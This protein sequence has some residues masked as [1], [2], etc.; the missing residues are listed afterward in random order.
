MGIFD[1]KSSQSGAEGTVGA[2]TEAGSPTSINL[3]AG[4]DLA[5]ATV[6]V[7]NEF[8]DPGALDLAARIS[9]GSIDVLSEFAGTVERISGD[10]FTTAN[11]L[12][13]ASLDV[14]RDFGRDALELGEEALNTG[15]RA[16][17]ANTTVSL[18]A[19]NLS[20]DVSAGAF[21]LAADL[22]DN[23]AIFA[24]D[25][26][27][28]QGALVRDLFERTVTAVQDTGARFLNSA[29]EL[30]ARESTNTEGRLEAVTNR[31]ILVGGGVLAIA[32]AVAGFAV[33][34]R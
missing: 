30:V 18:E 21:D 15:R 10:A 14:A 33:A 34:R 4:D 6:N 23:Q 3:A 25:V 2:Q 16:V 5:R 9:D 32:L 31:S 11:D 7:T 29:S 17:D 12:G 20:D 19:L 1:S 27:G 26:L 24:S 13:D 22:A 8:I 28:E